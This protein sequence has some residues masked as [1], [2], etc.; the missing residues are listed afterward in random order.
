MVDAKHPEDRENRTL[1]A[2]QRVAGNVEVTWPEHKPAGDV[3]T[4]AR[5]FWKRLGVALARCE[6]IQEWEAGE[7]DYLAAEIVNGMLAFSIPKDLGLARFLYAE[8]DGALTD[9]EWKLYVEASN[10]RAQVMKNET[11][12]RADGLDLRRLQQRKGGML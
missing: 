4:T 9:V 1:L 2:A 10:V 8:I 11:I 3:T 7:D 6:Y 12:Q 5:Y